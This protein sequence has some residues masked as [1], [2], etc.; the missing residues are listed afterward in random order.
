MKIQGPKQTS[1]TSGPKK[2]SGVK[3]ASG[4]NF[5]EFV[6]SLSGAQGPSAAGAPQSVASVASLLAAQSVEDPT[7]KAAR[8]KMI[9]R[10][11]LVLEELDKLHLAV[12]RGAVSM[13]HM[14]GIAD[15]VSA[16]KERV[17]DAKLSALLAEIDL[18]AQVELAKMRKALD[19]GA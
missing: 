7:E 6:S 1:G 4:G 14:I 5:E 11:D 17:T 2:S 10:A 18:R 8:K 19:K 3:G 12:L 9:R 15:M 16:H 13:D